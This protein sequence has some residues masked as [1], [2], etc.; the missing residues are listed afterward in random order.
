MVHPDPKPTPGTRQALDQYG[1]M[2][3]LRGAFSRSPSLVRSGSQ[4]GALGKVGE[5]HISGKC[6]GPAVSSNT[7]DSL[8]GKVKSIVLGT[9]YH[10]EKSTVSGRPLIPH[11]QEY[12]SGP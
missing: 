9:S 11:I 1:C 4:A 5:S 3:K 8:Q 6:R 7:G 2:K 12:C 10:K